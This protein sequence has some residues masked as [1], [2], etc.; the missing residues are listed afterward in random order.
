MPMQ[1]GGIQPVVRL[2]TTPRGVRHPTHPFRVSHKP[3]VLQPFLIAPVLAG[4]SLDNINIRSRAVLKDQDRLAGHWLSHQVFY[5]KLT[6]LDEREA[7]VAMLID[8]TNE[9]AVPNPVGATDPTWYRTVGTMDFVEMCL[10]TVCDHYW[11]FEGEAHDDFTA[12]IGGIERPIAPIRNI[13]WIDSMQNYATLPVGADVDVDL[14]ADAT[15]TASEIEQA[16]MRYHALLQQGNVEISWEEY[17]A[18]FGMKI[19]PES[20]HI[21]ERLFSRTL[22]QLPSNTVDVSDNTTVTAVSWQVDHSMNS[23]KVFKEPGFIFGVTYAQRKEYLSG[24]SG[25]ASGLLWKS[26]AWLS[27]A[28]MNSGAYSLERLSDD[29]AGHAIVPSS[30]E[31]SVGAGNGKDLIFDYK[32]LYLYGDQFFVP[33]ATDVEPVAALPDAAVRKRYHDDAVI[34]AMPDVVQDGTVM[35]T[36]NSTVFDTSAASPDAAL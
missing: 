12:T 36:I 35:L 20:L 14:N 33:N 31:S 8:A 4:D 1:R 19:A 29:L 9:K 16:Q 13:G 21:P 24:L 25:N 22:W 5:V 15:I 30:V 18:K 10:Q 2:A 23:R 32:D 27:D 26:S 6:D 11:R 34:E 28:L 3:Y 7:L 17:L